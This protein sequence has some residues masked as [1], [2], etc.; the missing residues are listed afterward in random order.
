M[1]M[2]SSSSLYGP[3]F[4]C[5]LTYNTLYFALSSLVCNSVMNL[6]IRYTFT[7]YDAFYMI[8]YLLLVPWNNYGNYV[9]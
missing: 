9:K 8:T 2:F 4:I 1:L 6:S 3:L 7:V 5:L